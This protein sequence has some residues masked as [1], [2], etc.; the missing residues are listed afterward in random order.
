MITKDE[1]YVAMNEQ[2]KITVIRLEKLIDEI[3]L[4]NF[5][6]H[7]TTH[8]LDTSVGSPANNMVITLKGIAND[9]WKPLSTGITNLD[10]RISDVLPPGKVLEKGIYVMQFNTKNYYEEKGQKGFYPE[11]S[12]QFEV[13]DDS[14]YHIPLLINPYGYSTYRGS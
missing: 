12:I 6:S 2:H 8:A 5:R 7:I 4:G 11:V 13:K 1:L 3:S 14:H 10:G 9:E